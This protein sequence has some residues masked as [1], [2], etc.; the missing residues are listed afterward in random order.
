MAKF[1]PENCEKLA[2]QIVDSM[3]INDLCRCMAEHLEE[4]YIQDEDLFQE[5][6]EL[7]FGEDE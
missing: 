7:Y 2:C 6:W 4:S 5:G 3:D 1:T